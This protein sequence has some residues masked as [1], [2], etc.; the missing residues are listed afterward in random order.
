MS[1]E[2]LTK[3]T[4]EV[5][6]KEVSRRKFVAGSMVAGAAAASGLLNAVPALAG[7]GT[8]TLKVNGE[9]VGTDVAPFIKDGRTM[10]PIRF[11]GEALQTDVGWDN[12]TRTA[13]VDAKEF[14]FE[15]KKLD[16]EKARKAGFD[17]YFKGKG[18]MYGAAYGLL[19]LLREAVGYPYTA[20][21]LDAFKFGL[22]GATAGSLC[23]A[24]NG[25][26]FVMGL[27]LGNDI[28]KADNN[29][30]KKLNDWYV[31]TELP[32]N[33]KHTAWAK[34]AVSEPWKSA[35]VDCRDSKDAWCAKFNYVSGGDEQKQRCAKLTGDVCAKAVEILNEYFGL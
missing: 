19:T 4:E 11:I 29:S 1:E 13:T 25:A 16:P 30:M 23:G 3:V 14:T 24:Q 21:P 12:A 22:G 17:G 15:Y 33:D 2:K 18:C 6:S 8:V 20:I 28:N 32:L 31:G 35:T 5:T 34:I 27:I 26:L 9:V 10:V 7:T